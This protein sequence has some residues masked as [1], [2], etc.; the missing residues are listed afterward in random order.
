MVG[1]LDKIKMGINS[2]NPIGNEY[3]KNVESNDASISMKDVFIMLTV[4]WAIVVG[5]NII[6]IIV[7]LMLVGLVASAMGSSRSMIGG[8]SGVGALAMESATSSVVSGI[9]MQIPTL[10]MGVF[11]V[12]LIYLYDIIGRTLSKNNMDK[13]ILTHKIGAI[14]IGLAVVGVVGAVVGLIPCIGTLIAILLEIAASIIALVATYK[15]L[16]KGYKMDAVLT[17]VT[18][19]ISVGVVGA[20]F[21]AFY[22]VMYFIAVGSSVLL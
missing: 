6:H 19:I 9:I 10:F 16:S 3:L 21:V 8:H 7:G 11:G 14:M 22:F 18:I 1:F 17:I 2:L 5:I 20:A 15:I 12:A 13:K 4:I